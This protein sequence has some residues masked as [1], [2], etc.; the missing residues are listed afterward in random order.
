MKPTVRLAFFFPK[1]YQAKAISNQYSSLSIKHSK[2]KPASAGFFLFYTTSI[3]L[4]A[5]LL[6][7]ILLLSSQ[8]QTGHHCLFGK[9]LGNAGFHKLGKDHIEINNLP[10]TVP[11]LENNLFR[12]GI[13]ELELNLKTVPLP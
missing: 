2:E 5:T 10:F 11:D 13:K 12:T 9:D 6:Y 4:N 8:T 1:T 7:S 3:L